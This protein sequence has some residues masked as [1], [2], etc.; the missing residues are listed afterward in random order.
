MRGPHDSSSSN[1]S[2]FP[3]AYRGTSWLTHRSD[4]ST[5]NLSG[6]STFKSLS[7]PD[8]II[9]NSQFG[10][11]DKSPENEGK[12]GSAT[13]QPTVDSQHVISS[14]KPTIIP[15]PDWTLSKTVGSNSNS[16]STCS[17]SATP[18][19]DLPTGQSYPIDYKSSYAS[20]TSDAADR[21]CVF[22]ALDTNLE[23]NGSGSQMFYASLKATGE[24]Q[25]RTAVGDGMS[26][27]TSSHT[28]RAVAGQPVAKCS[29]VEDSSG[30]DSG[31]LV[32]G[33]CFSRQILNF[34]ADNRSCVEAWQGSSDV[35]REHSGD[36]DG[37]S[38]SLSLGSEQIPSFHPVQVASDNEH[39]SSV[40]P[41]VAPAYCSKVQ[42]S[43][44]LT[45]N[46]LSQYLPVS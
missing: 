7:I 13:F 3:A 42:R 23:S 20:P 16:V 34:A 15:R 18:L 33:D 39:L 29:E 4:T 1:C 28:S 2:L 46:D 8:V 31:V 35:S 22:K 11:S 25:N 12:V 36:I 10:S 24:A 19:P 32:T 38:S 17:R 37:S 41:N 6:V 26:T 44:D 40:P 9:E 30:H 5:T 43:Q 45:Q 14:R 27:D 21:D